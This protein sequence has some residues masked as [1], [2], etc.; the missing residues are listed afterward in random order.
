MQYYLLLVVTCLLGGARTLI[1]KFH[2]KRFGEGVDNSFLLTC[3]TCGFFVP[4]A[5]LAGARFTFTPMAFWLAFAFAVVNVLCSVIGFAVLPIGN[6]SMYTLFL[7]MG[8]MLIPFAYGLAFNGD[9]LSLG[10]TLCILLILYALAL[11][12]TKDEKR[13][14]KATL[15]YLLIFLLN[16][17]ACVLIT[18]H[19]TEALGGTAISSA[20]FTLWYAALTSLLCLLF[21]GARLATG[22]KERMAA[23]FPTET[24]SVK[25]TGLRLLLALFSGVSYGFGN[26]LLTIC[27]LHVEP[28]AQFP[29]ITGGSILVSGLFGLFIGE[30]ITKKFVLSTSAVM[31]GC[32]LLLLA[33][34]GLP[35]FS[36]SF[37]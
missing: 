37:Y 16:G 15:Y 26:L 35:F 31:V 21:L 19:Q 6:M 24:R 18:L 25:S 28:S 33:E 7:Q 22:G 5:M 14:K 8:G 30:K 10:N 2:L 13:S 23:L 20:D 17:L 1:N 27:L 3:L 12:L 4:V 32:I 9:G 34:V 36:F 29:F 11:N